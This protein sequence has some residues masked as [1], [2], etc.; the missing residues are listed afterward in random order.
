MRALLLLLPFLAAC[1]L[2]VELVYPGHR[3][4]DLGT[5]SSYCAHTNT[6]LDYSFF[7]EGRLDWLEFYWLPEGVRP[8]DARPEEWAALGGPV[9]GGAVRGFVE[10][11]PQGAIRA[12]SAISAQGGVPQGI[13]VEPSQPRRL[14]VRGFTGGL[15]G[16][17]VQGNPVY[18]DTSAFCDPAW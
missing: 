1:S 2:T 3:I 6:R 9:Y 16:P 8:E 5:Q 4:S 11:T 13:S 15:A 17:F 7:L 12:V 14:W 18:S 10:V